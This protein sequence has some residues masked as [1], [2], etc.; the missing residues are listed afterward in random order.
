MGFWSSIFGKKEKN[1]QQST[2][3]PEQQNLWGQGYNAMQGQGAGGAYG[4]TADYYRSLLAGDSQTEQAMGAPMMRQFNEQTIPGLSEQFAGMGS[5]GLSSSSFRNAGVGAGVDLQE[6]LANIRAQ[7]R[8]QGAQG[9][10]GMYGQMMQPTTGNVHRP[11]TYGLLGGLA[12][13][14]GM[15][16]GMGAAMGMPGMVGA[17]MNAANSWW[18]QK[19]PQQFQES[20]WSRVGSGTIGRR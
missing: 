17:G 14:A 13:G 18:G 8:Q 19:Q 7:L 20:P 1:Y 5:G 10:Q 4:D 12:Q 9:L 2:L 11:E 6:R 15:G 3:S 16:I